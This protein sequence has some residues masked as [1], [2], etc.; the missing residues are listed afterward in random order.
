MIALRELKRVP[1]NHKIVI[2][3]PEN[4]A[5]NQLMEVILLFKEPPK[6]SRAEKIAL[7]KESQHDPLF[8]A[9]L[10]AVSDDFSAMDNEEW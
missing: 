6:M 3:V 10:Q 2:E 7:L 8:L 4:I 1:S 5:E 9:D